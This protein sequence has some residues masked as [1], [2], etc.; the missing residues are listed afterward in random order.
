VPVT[1][2]AVASA[3]RPGSRAGGWWNGTPSRA[4]R[5]YGG[6]VSETT[7]YDSAGD[8]VAYIADDSSTIYLWQGEAVAYVDGDRIYGWNG[9]HLGWFADGMI[10]DG[11][12]LRAGFVRERCPVVTR[13][14]PVKSVK[15]VR[16]VKSVRSIAPIRPVLS[17]SM[18]SLPLAEF[19][20]SGR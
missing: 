18:S 10:H 14:Q 19:L 1:S 5:F 12:G 16:R 15:Q 9:Q 8:A 2:V 3:V 7:L 13:V 6:L 4:K 20:E 17:H 11:G